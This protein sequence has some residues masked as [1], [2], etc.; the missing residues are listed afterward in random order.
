MSL[1]EIPKVAVR[2]AAIQETM[3]HLRAA[4]ELGCEGI[5]LWVGQ[6]Q[7]QRLTVSEAYIPE[8]YGV[9]TASG[10]IAFVDDEALHKLGV[11]LY[12][13]RLELIAQIHSHPQ[14]A[15]HSD[16]DDAYA[17]ATKQ[18]A[19]SLVV[20]NFGAEPFAFANCAIY[21]LR[22][23]GWVVMSAKEVATVFEIQD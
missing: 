22:H 12:E 15:Y 13:R 2:A 9:R 21:R 14:D 1:L 16:T 19:F 7:S 23:E 5:A 20:P 17:I 10:L 18:G 8:Q 4:G 6:T 11:W 3:A